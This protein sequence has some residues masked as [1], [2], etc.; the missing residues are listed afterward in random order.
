MS[1]PYYT[2]T[3]CSNESPYEQREV[4]NECVISF[5]FSSANIWIVLDFIRFSYIYLYVGRCEQVQE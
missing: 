5:L 1:D 2:T 3:T 4:I